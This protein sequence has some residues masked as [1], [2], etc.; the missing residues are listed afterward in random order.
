[1]SLRCVE[2][3][4]LASFLASMAASIPHLAKVFPSFFNMDHNGNIISVTEDR[5][6]YTRNQIM[7]VVNTINQRA[8]Q[9]PLQGLDSLTAIFQK[10]FVVEDNTQNSNQL[11]LQNQSLDD[12][13][14][15]STTSGIKQTA[16]KLIY[17]HLMKSFLALLREKLKEEADLTV[18][19]PTKQHVDLSWQELLL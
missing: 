9:G 8:P 12:S 11:Q 5:E 2:S 15:L 10:L 19:N 3:T 13:Y 6:P 7:E 16:Q 4:Y 1:M 17:S 14:A 18:S